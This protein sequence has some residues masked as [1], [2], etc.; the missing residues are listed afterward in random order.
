MITTIFVI[1][2]MIAAIYYTWNAA[3]LNKLNRKMFSEFKV[4]E[5]KTLLQSHVLESLHNLH[6]AE[7]EICASLE[8]QLN[9]WKERNRLVEKAMNPTTHFR[10]K[11]IRGKRRK[12]GR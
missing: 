8:F 7:R 1:I 3:R 11:K 12:S 10:K 5:S 4:L 9:V 6:I 2:T